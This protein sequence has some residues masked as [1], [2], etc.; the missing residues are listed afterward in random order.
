[1][2][3]CL[4]VVGVCFLAVWLL[5]C[6]FVFLWLFVVVVFVVAFV[7]G[8]VVVYAL[9]VEVRECS[10]CSGLCCEARRKSSARRGVA[11]SLKNRPTLT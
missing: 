5:A 3:V 8:F 2:V 11:A 4:C 6:L 7:V 10:L 9:A 1:M